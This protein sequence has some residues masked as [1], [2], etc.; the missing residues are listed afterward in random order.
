VSGP[1]RDP[2]VARSRPER[3]AVVTLARY[4]AVMVGAASQ[5]PGEP[6]PDPFPTDDEVAERA[7]ELCFVVRSS[8]LDGV[9]SLQ[10]AEQELLDRSARRACRTEHSSAT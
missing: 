1:D 3:H 9:G 7:F 6:L 5:N 2:A 10:A 8:C 4:P